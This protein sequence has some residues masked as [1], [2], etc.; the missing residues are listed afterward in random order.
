MPEIKNTFIKSKMNKDLDARLL[1]NGEYRD[2]INVSVS[3]SEGPDVGAV[4]NIIGNKI[5]ANFGLNDSNL[6]FIGFGQDQTNDL[7]FCFLT[8]YEDNTN[9]TFGKFASADASSSTTSKTKTAS[10]HYICLHNLKTNA[11]HILAQGPFLNF[12][13]TNRITNVNVLEDLLFWTDDR[14]Q[15]RKL[16]WRRALENGPNYYSKEDH[17][18]VSKYAPVNS[19]QFV[20][21]TGLPLGIGVAPAQSRLEPCWRNETEKY[22]PCFYATTGVFKDDS[23]GDW[24]FNIDIANARPGYD[25]DYFKVTVNTTLGLPLGVGGT[26]WDKNIKVINKTKNDG[27]EVWVYQVAISSVI[28]PGLFDAGNALAFSSVAPDTAGYAHDVDTD[29]LGWESGDVLEFFML[30]PD[31][32]ILFDGDK[33]FLKEKFPRFSYRFKYDDDE[34]SLIA[35]WSQVSFVPNQFGY[36][37]YNDDEKIKQTSVVEFMKNW[38]TT[39]DLFFKLPSAPNELLEDLHIKEIQLLYNSSDEENV[40]VLADLKGSDLNKGCVARIAALGSLPVGS[41]Y[42]NGTF[43]IELPSVSGKGCVCQFTFAGGQLTAFGTTPTGLNDAKGENYTLNEAIEVPDGAGGGGSGAFITIAEL[44]NEYLYTYSS[45]AP[46]KTLPQK[47]L[48]RVSDIT[49]LKA[50]TQEVVGNR[51]MY[52]NFIQNS[53]TPS[54][55]DYSLSISEKNVS[56]FTNASATATDV[57]QFPNHTLKQNRSYQVGVV[58]YD[59]YGRAS[60]VILNDE[61]SNS[62]KSK[63]TVFAPLTNGGVDP[64][65]WTGNNIKITFNS[66]IE[67]VKTD[68]YV[69]LWSETNPLGWYSY[70]VVVKQVE[71]EYYNVYV[72][73][74][75]SGNVLYKDNDT[76]IDYSNLNKFAH[77]ALFNNNINKV[78]K[79]LQTIGPS[80]NLYSS[81]VELFCRVA[82]TSISTSSFPINTT[83]NINER[84]I[85]EQKTIPTGMD[86]VTL[87]SFR[88]FGD[89]TSRKGVDGFWETAEWDQN[90]APSGAWTGKPNYNLFCYPDNAS[91]TATP[92]APNIPSGS[93]PVDPFFLDDNKNPVIATISTS[94]R[95]GFTREFQY[96]PSGTYTTKIFSTRLGIYET[97]PKKEQLDLFY[98]TSTSGLISEL[99]ESITS[100]LP[101]TFPD[102]ITSFFG[103]FQENDTP[104]TPASNAFEVIDTVGNKINDPLSIV[105]LVSVTDSNGNI[106]VPSPF[107]INEVTPG[108]IGVSPTFEVR[109]NTLFVYDSQS[110]IQDEYNLT[111]TAEDGSGNVS[112]PFVHTL[113]LTNV[114]P[115]ILRGEVYRSWFSNLAAPYNQG[116]ALSYSALVANSTI[117]SV[118]SNLYNGQFGELEIVNNPYDD[119]VAVAP[120]EALTQITTFNETPD[121]NGHTGVIAINNFIPA[122]LEPRSMAL[123]A[124]FFLTQFSPQ[125]VSGGGTYISTSNQ[126]VGAKYWLPLI[127][128][129]RFEN[130]SADTANNTHDLFFRVANSWIKTGTIPKNSLYLPANEGNNVF[131]NFSEKGWYTNNSNTYYNWQGEAGPWSNNSIY[132]GGYWWGSY[133]N[134]PSLY[135]TF[136]MTVPP[137]RQSSGTAG[138]PGNW[139]YPGS[140]NYWRAYQFTFDISCI[141]AYGG[142]SNGAAGSLPSGTFRFRFYVVAD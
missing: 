107:Q 53:E 1:P 127:S 93:D 129:T 20:K 57:I 27:V 84:S 82:Y 8:N 106:V 136:P 15:P 69:G 50:K 104:G 34:Y 75:L 131:T 26:A 12:S 88:E 101:T 49:P 111:M 79:D 124:S 4:E 14:N 16:N 118:D 87:K 44:T 122:D 65:R 54:K 132:N 23:S 103:S 35:P 58:L 133:G 105:N 28:Y 86:V 21:D 39:V 42:T 67:S 128:F 45:Q 115:S 61:N 56:E 3:T 64:L 22:L 81:D 73:G 110:S 25:S 78:P 18:S 2:A 37:N 52:G 141:D 36:F 91:P 130:G 90:I 83:A 98:E 140:E 19:I 68:S 11:S 51:V 125:S 70:R 71:H 97:K 30:N 109:T 116:N 126:I 85:S 119:P 100:G 123:P 32:N 48:F 96:N 40:K 38:I 137:V 114:Q 92:A 10:R 7:V 76:Q 6:D 9:S 31:Y 55:L 80:D 46:I 24:W 62:D 102:N 89:W 138:S 59:R 74:A 121:S 94:Q 29:S 113:K 77:L 33:D 72:P 43:N 134:S 5:I 95:V 13:K 117:N 120:K 60:N 112:A 47:T 17:I 63:S 66:P 135:S 139:D 142:L 108:S 41:G 99:N